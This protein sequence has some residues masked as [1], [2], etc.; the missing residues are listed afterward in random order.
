[1]ESE[2]VIWMFD[3][4]EAAYINSIPVSKLGWNFDNKGVYIVKSGYKLLC[5]NE[6]VSEVSNR[7]VT[8]GCWSKIWNIKVPTKIQI[9]IWRIIHDILPIRVNLVNRRIPSKQICTKCELEEK[10]CSH[11]F[12]SCPVSHEV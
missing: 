12:R 10:D 5:N 1:M 8:D 2:F 11:A 4:E 6:D 3:T 9:F 7:K